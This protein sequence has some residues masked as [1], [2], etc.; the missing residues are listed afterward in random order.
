MHPAGIS[1][2]EQC[3]VRQLGKSCLTYFARSGLSPEV[4]TTASFGAKQRFSREAVLLRE[5]CRE[6]LPGRE[7]GK[8][9]CFGTGLR[10]E[11]GVLACKPLLPSCAR[12]AFQLA[13]LTG[14]ARPEPRPTLQSNRKKWGPKFFKP[15]FFSAFYRKTRT[16]SHMAAPYS[17]LSSRKSF[18][19]HALH[20]CEEACQVSCSDLMSFMHDLACFWR[21]RDGSG[22]EAVHQ[23]QDWKWPTRYRA[24]LSG[25]R[26]VL[27]SGH[28]LYLFFLPPYVT[29]AS[30]TKSG[31][32]PAL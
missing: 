2:S 1:H 27:K 29:P 4:V 16:Y 21:W 11:F 31:A 9:L 24:D 28:A 13:A 32:P 6:A 18:P 20:G 22:V 5:G 12:L 30:A 14:V 17:D 8:S 26:R 3:H 23:N 15:R 7:F 19:R 25:T 10:L